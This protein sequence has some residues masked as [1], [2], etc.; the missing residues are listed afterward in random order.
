MRTALAPFLFSLL[1]TSA[2]DAAQSKSRRLHRPTVAIPG[3]NKFD[4]QS[5]AFCWNIAKVPTP[6]SPSATAQTPIDL[7]RT[8]AQ[9]NL[10]RVT[11]TPQDAKSV[12]ASLARLK[13]A[14]CGND[15][16]EISEAL[17]EACPHEG[18]QTEQDALS[19]AI[20]HGI[21][22]T[23]QILLGHRTYWDDPGSKAPR[24]PRPLG[25]IRS[26]GSLLLAAANRGNPAIAR[27]LLP[28][29]GPQDFEKRDAARRTPSEVAQANGYQEIGDIFNEDQEK[30]L[31]K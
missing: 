2:M 15:I 6:T 24:S 5:N 23:V 10:P 16:K 31:K 22:T 13:A 17:V 19:L 8:Y 4:K 12:P 11:S 29:A 3:N 26:I 28:H 9:L 30:K 20:A 21:P 18:W 14:V 25:D 27:A 1:F 7:N